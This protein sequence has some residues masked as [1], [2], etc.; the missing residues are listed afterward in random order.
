MQTS[1]LSIWPDYDRQGR[2][3]TG[4]TV[5]EDLTASLRDLDR[6]GRVISDVV[7]AAGDAARIHSISFEVDDDEALLQQAREDAIADAR[8]RAKTYAGAAGRSV[9]QVLRISEVALDRPEIFPIAERFA[10]EEM[11]GS[12][13]IA[14]GSQELSV[15]VTVEWAFA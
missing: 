1:G 11:A 2:R 14:E 8:V 13:P 6:A 12:V 5:T 7:A 4:Y 15:T 10:A 9:G 3:I